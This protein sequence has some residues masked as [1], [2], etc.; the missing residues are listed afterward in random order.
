MNLKATALVPVTPP[1][2]ARM[3]VPALIAGA[4][5]RAAWR[6]VEFFTVN[7]RNPNT[8]ARVNRLLP[9]PWWEAERAWRLGRAGLSW[10]TAQDLG[11][12]AQ[13]IIRQRL[14]GESLALKKFVDPVPSPQGTL[15]LA[16][17]TAG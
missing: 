10:D 15:T 2:D 6:F 13:P 1:F 5:K 9:S 8:R 12:R 11:S 4:G 17:Q 14:E 7:I 16:D 3:P